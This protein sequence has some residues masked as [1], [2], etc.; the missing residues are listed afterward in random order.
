M[1]RLKIDTLTFILLFVSLVYTPFKDTLPVLGAIT[2]HEI[3]HIISARLMRIEIKEVE[4]NILGA[5]IHT[6]NSLFS[7]RMEVFLALSGPLINLLLFTIIIISQS[8]WG[9]DS[10]KQ[11]AFCNLALG[12]LNLLPVE[13]FDGGRIINGLLSRFLSPRTVL[14][15]SHFL[16]FVVIFLLWLFSVYFLLR[17]G[18]SIALFIFCAALFSKMINREV[19][20]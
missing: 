18:T 19:F 4:L 14:S 16:S 10:I 15:I 7:Y 8:L 11:F 1:P 6:K 9:N 5:K 13:G 20:I 12:L 3:S 17:T 2:I